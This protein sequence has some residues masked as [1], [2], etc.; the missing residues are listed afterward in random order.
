M[1]LISV[2]VVD[3][4]DQAIDHIETY[5]S[6]HTESIITDDLNAADEFLR[7]VVL[8]DCAAQRV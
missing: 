2:R 6:H 5:G 1:R 3:G 8:G 4:L 7:L